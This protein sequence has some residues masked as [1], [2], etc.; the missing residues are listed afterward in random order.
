MLSCQVTPRVFSAQM[1]K[2]LGLRAEVGFVGEH[3]QQ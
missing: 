1:L 3:L 2:V